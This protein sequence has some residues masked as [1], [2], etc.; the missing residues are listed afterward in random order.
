MK[1]CMP[2]IQFK[3]ARLWFI[4]LKRP[5][6]RF[7]L[8]IHLTLLDSYKN[9]NARESMLNLMIQCMLKVLTIFFIPLE[10]I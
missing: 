1:G 7:P 9:S 10:S 8:P 3:V 4:N 6:Y 2:W 5:K